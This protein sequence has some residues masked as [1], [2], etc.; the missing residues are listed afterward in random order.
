MLWIFFS[1]KAVLALVADPQHVTALQTAKGWV[2]VG[3]TAALIFALC[4]R[5]VNDTHSA[6][7]VALQEIADLRQSYEQQTAQIRAR[8]NYI[9]EVVNNSAEAIVTLDERG[10]IETYNPAAAKVFGYSAEEAIGQ[11]IAL[12][13]PEHS[14][15][16]HDVYMNDSQQFSKT[17]LNKPRDILTVR[18][19]GEEFP[20]RINI[21]Q[22]SVR[23]EH[24]YV[25]IMRDI[26]ER[27]ALE[28]DLRF[29]KTMAEQ[30]N[31]SKSEFLSSMSHELRT[32]LNAIIGFSESMLS[33]VF[34]QIENASHTEYLGHINASGELLLE[35][36]NE[37]LDLSKIEAGKLDLR[38]EP[39]SPCD[40]IALCTDMFQDQAKKHDIS[41]DIATGNTPNNMVN[42]DPRRLRQVLMNL[43]SNAIKYNTTGGK[44]T[45]DCNM[46]TQDR[47]RILVTDTGTGISAAEMTKLF[48]PFN[49]LH[50]EHSG[51]PGTGIGLTLSKKLMEEMNGEIGVESVKGEGSTF[52]IELPKVTYQHTT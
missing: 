34:G 46:P 50:A 7:N 22:M 19:N 51:I 25:A 43:I 15:A 29:A 44:L 21:S 8:E 33:G 10:K 32:P 28:D 47:L 16:V 42:A 38:L 9:R 12:V 26:T 2:F 5:L 4:R 14:R 20:L 40:M 24:K 6:H 1:D 39:T 37:V 41:I 18:K 13:I 48:V 49:R 36:I 35:L 23:D 17:I 30:A 45:I 11:S 52:W 27:K 31:R 3:L